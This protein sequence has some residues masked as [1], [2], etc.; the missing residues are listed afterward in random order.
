MSNQQIETQENVC[1]PI[2]QPTKT[3]RKTPIASIILI[4]ISLVYEIINIVIRSLQYTVTAETIAASIVSEIATILVLL[5]MIFNK[6]NRDILC[7]AGVLVWA[8]LNTYYLFTELGVYSTILTL[9]GAVARALLGVSFLVGK[10]QFSRPVKNISII[11]LMFTFIAS[12][13]ITVVNIV[14]ILNSVTYQW[15]YYSISYFGST[16]LN[17]IMGPLS[18]VALLLYSPY[19][20]E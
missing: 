15:G 18:F 5:G 8:C 13:A 3:A 9:I 16:L 7:G 6:K 12:V 4:S 2:S 19:N 14:A 10:K 1:S 17:I 11:I 20:N